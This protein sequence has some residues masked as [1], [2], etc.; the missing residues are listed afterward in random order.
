M[1]SNSAN[2]NKTNLLFLVADQWRGDALGHAGNTAVHTPNLDALVATDAISF[3]RAFCQAPVCSPSRC[4]FLTGWYPHVR[5]HRTMHNL[6]QED[7]PML[8]KSL[9]AN[10]YHVLWGGRNDTIP[11]ER[12]NGAEGYCTE[13]YHPESEATAAHGRYVRHGETKPGWRGA[14]DDKGFY[15]FYI[16]EEPLPE[17]QDGY[18]D[19]DFHLSQKGVDF[20]RNQPDAPWCCYLS[21]HDPHVPFGAPPPFYGKTARDA[22]PPRIPTPDWTDKPSILKG[23]HQRMRLDQWQDES[24]WNELRATYF[25][26]CHRMDWLF[27]RVIDALKASGEYENT[28]IIIWSDHGEFNG[29]YGLVEKTQNT[30]E[31]CLTRVPL[32]VKPP[33][34]RSVAQP[35]TRDCLT[36]LV[37]ISATSYDLAGISDPGYTAFGRS[38][39]PVITGESAQH[40]DAVFAEGGRFEHEAHC[41]ESESVQPQNTEAP[42]WPRMSLQA[43]WPAHGKGH[44]CRTDRYKYVIRA[45]EPDEFYDLAS[46]PGELH[47]RINDS[48]LQPEITRHKERLLQHLFETADVVPHQ[49]N[50]RF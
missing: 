17:G 16:G 1:N 8:F 46:D 14:P 38:L 5:G 12:P 22:L 9:M 25:D 10:G 3:T 41:S 2:Q 19:N 11:A 30:F 13:R 6:L 7:E 23:L 47:N 29:D 50:R 43:E 15:S 45:G 27:G 35:G 28:A 31:D 34:D 39:M 18:Y 21:F 40:R 26:M 24:E 42:Y 44:M 37:D 48:D 32:I 4:S 49:Q 33:A 20:M 36:E